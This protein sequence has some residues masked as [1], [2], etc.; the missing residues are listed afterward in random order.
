MGKTFSEFLSLYWYVFLE[1]K[2]SICVD[3]SKK[4]IDTTILFFGYV[5]THN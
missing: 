4:N 3:N 5:S 1:N 2:H